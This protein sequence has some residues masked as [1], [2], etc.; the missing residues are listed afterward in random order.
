MELKTLHEECLSATVVEV[1][2]QTPSLSQGWAEQRIHPNVAY[3]SDSFVF[4][5]PIHGAMPR[6][7]A[8]LQFLWLTRLRERWLGNGA[9]RSRK[10][11]PAAQGSRYRRLCLEV[12]EDRLLLNS[13]PPVGETWTKVTP[14]PTGSV[15]TM[16][17]L[18]D[19]GVMVQGANDTPVNTWYELK[20]DASGNYA[21]GA[22]K[23]L[24]HMSHGRLFF[25]SAVM[26]NDQAFV[27][28]G[29]YST[30]WND[31]NT[32]EVYD[33]A[34][35][36]WKSTPDFAQS[37]F[38]DDPT[39]T[40]P[41]GNVLGGFLIGPETYEYN[42]VTNTWSDGPTKLDGDD[43][44]EETWI[45]LPASAALPQ[46][47]ILSW[48][49]F[50]SIH[51][52]NFIGQVLNI[53]T[54]QWIETKNSTTNPPALLSSHDIGYELGP[55]L[56]LPNGKVLQ[57]GANGNT[58]LYDP[59]TNTWSAGPQIKDKNG[60]L[61]GPDDAPASIL[62]DGQVIFTADAGP[63]SGAFSPPTEMFDYEY[64]TNTNTQ[65]TGL[66]SA[67]NSNLINSSA[68]VDR[69]LVLPSGQL[70]FTDASNLYLFTPNDSAQDAWRPSISKVVKTSSNTYTLTGLKLSGLSEGSSYGDDV[71]VSENYP[72]V[73]L[74]SGNQVYYATT[75]NWSNVLVS[76]LGDTTV[77]SVDFTLPDNIPDGN[78]QLAVIANGISSAP[79]QITIGLTKVETLAQNAATMTFSTNNQTQ[80]LTADV[81]ELSGNQTVNS[82]SVTFTVLDSSGNPVGQSVQGA[83][84]GGVA[85]ANFTL[86]ANASVGTYTV[87]VS[88]SDN[89]DTY[90]DGG[91]TSG[92]LTVLGSGVTV[93]GTQLWIVGGTNT[94]D[95]INVDPAG[96]SKTGSTG[97]K[98]EA[99]LN[100][101]HSTTTYHQDFTALYIFVYGGNDK[102]DVAKTLTINTTVNGG[103]G[104]D[105]VRLGE[106]NNTVTLGD[107]NDR[108]AAGDGNN[109][110][111]LG[112][113][114]DKV[115][116][117]NGA[118][119]VTV[120]NGND[121]IKVGNGNNALVEGNGNDEIDAGN[122]NNLIV[123]SL[124]R[125][126]VDVGKGSNILID[127]SV[128]LTQSGDSLRQVLDDW[129]EYGAQA[130]NVASIRSR[131]SVMY[132]THYANGLHAGS[133]LDWFWATDSHDSLNAKPTDSRN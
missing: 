68:F 128:Q 115:H 122:G 92:T 6:A 18:P 74:T 125:H 21:S 121:H 81:R 108:D 113:G 13:G 82:G 119:T 95:H 103:N 117:G 55:G 58:A 78:Y 32:G 86:P 124:G 76:P 60:N 11:H 84:N 5:R 40:L 10:R 25:G 64:T 27:V 126:A 49:I 88:Y 2:R 36:T 112:N 7:N 91:D 116:L 56:A 93:V 46:G 89:T 70:L 94:N 14:I 85:A 73:Q 80:A 12:L 31:D 3:A 47:G 90:G 33:M 72:I 8:M 20:P 114:K 30:V 127:G 9:G 87:A 111:T 100:H 129:I 48:S 71:N 109:D 133:G 61:M 23:Q 41:N 53:A 101:V 104:N 83:V 19:G 106:G 102:I 43:S 51:S 37:M 24:A 65:M 34:T 17:L 110:V 97:L 123:A 132:N 75:S 35:N 77:E 57:L 50:A 66:P 1:V 59:S 107:G 67:L 15:G 118:N 96:R 45:K 99:T 62:P 28:G 120:G 44:D 39:V 22:W 63:T 42:P 105:R 4:V 29:E 26:P 130:A 98:V 131:L 79:Q 54:G 69:T 16:L 52:G 38:G